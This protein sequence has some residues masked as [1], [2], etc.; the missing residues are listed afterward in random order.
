MSGGCEHW[1]LKQKQNFRL[2]PLK[3]PTAW[4]KRQKKN[5]RITDI[6]RKEAD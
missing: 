2:V 5:F 4:I 3:D 6:D 1:Y